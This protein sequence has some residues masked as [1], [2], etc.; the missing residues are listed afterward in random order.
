MNRKTNQEKALE[1]YQEKRQSIAA[2][3]ARIQDKLA[4]HADPVVCWGHVG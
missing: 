1:A 2:L 3:L 4:K